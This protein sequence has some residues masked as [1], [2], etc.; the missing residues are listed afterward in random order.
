MTKIK[1]APPQEQ[2]HRPLPAA[3][4]EL[5]VPP[6]VEGLTP[7]IVETDEL[8]RREPGS[9]FEGRVYLV[10]MEHD[11]DGA[12]TRDPVTD[13]HEDLGYVGKTIRNVAVRW[14]EHLSPTKPGEGGK[15]NNSAVYRHRHRVTGFSVDPRVY[16]TPEAL[17]AAERRAI[18][19]LW[20]AWNIQEQDRRNPASRAS[21]SYR[22]AD[23]L[24]PLIGAA[25]VLW[26]LYF[27]AVC[28][29]LLYV[30]WTAGAPWWGVVACPVIA[31]YLTSQAFGRHAR[32]LARHRSRR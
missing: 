7:T 11:P 19:T 30:A 10:W 2:A 26:G 12:C 27:A 20:P 28:A 31:T 1:E 22:K 23:R 5:F 14:R 9:R 8:E 13:P 6:R 25:A 29:G 3:L 24:A 21:R 16:R 17:A 32:K 18:R 15:K 4:A